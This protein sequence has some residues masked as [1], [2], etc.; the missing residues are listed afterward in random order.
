MGT[1]LLLVV[2]ASFLTAILTAGR[3]GDYT[4]E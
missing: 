2:C 4:E 3:E 1:V